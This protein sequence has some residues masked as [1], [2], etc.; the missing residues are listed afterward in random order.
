MKPRTIAALILAS[1]SFCI[2][3]FTVV[4]GERTTA[5][6][7]S[8]IT[9]LFKGESFSSWFSSSEDE[10]TTILVL[11]VDRFDRPDPELQAVWIVTIH[12]T[13]TEVL[14]SGVPTNLALDEAEAVQLR[15]FFAW[16]P[17]AG[18]TP[19]F[20]EALERALHIQVDTIVV[21]DE[22]GFA[23]LVDYLGGLPFE[24]GALSGDQV[25]ALHTVFRDDPLG[26][27]R[28]QASVLENIEP[29]V[30]KLGTA[31]DL[32]PLLALI[33]EHAQLSEHTAQFVLSV[34]HLLPLEEGQV[35]VEVI[36]SPVP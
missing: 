13:E 31:P 10:R 27:V 17:E 8:S 9:A 21:L 30:R 26:L 5:S 18:V 35:R 15:S 14:F 6:S 22:R 23:A 24:G 3:L 29:Q 2:G 33:P 34:S 12:P 20:I 1:V 7:G 19:P 28:L 25:L 36:L 11:G 16:S 32:E 4:M